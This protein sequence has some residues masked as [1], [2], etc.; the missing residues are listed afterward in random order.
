MIPFSPPA[1]GD[2]PS[3]ALAEALL[4]ERIPDHDG[5]AETLLAEEALASTRDPSSISRGCSG[6]C[7]SHLGRP[8]PFGSPDRAKFARYCCASERAL[9]GSAAARPNHSGVSPP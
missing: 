3:D 2:I 5:L 7:A 8:S 6:E 4:Q 1:G 9:R